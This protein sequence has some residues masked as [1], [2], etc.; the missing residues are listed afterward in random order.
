MIT[1][2]SIY[3]FVGAGCTGF[4]LG[5]VL[6]FVSVE[7]IGASRTLPLLRVQVPVA[8][9]LSIFFLEESLSPYH[10]FE[11]LVILLGA[12]LVSREVSNRENNPKSGFFLISPDLLIPFGAA[13]SW[14]VTWYFLR[15]G[16]KT[17][18]PI[19][20]GIAISSIVALIGFTIFRMIYESKPPYS[21]LNTKNRFWYIAISFVFA[22]SFVF[23]FL[24]LSISRVV[25][26][27]PIW[28]VSPLFVL[29]LSY[30]FLSKLEKITSKLTIGALLIVS[31]AV[32]VIIFM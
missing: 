20:L 32:M 3:P 19:V 16:M 15:M 13:F 30:F 6:L 21:G 25:V 14:G 26:V 24:A 7:R 18:T 10:L 29:F 4:F 12:G 2:K 28:Q 9:I 11:V 17:G 27:S 1:A 31:G 22:V 8:L 23:E 5:F